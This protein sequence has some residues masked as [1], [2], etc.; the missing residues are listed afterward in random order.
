VTDWTQYHPTQTLTTPDGRQADI[1]M[2]MV[3]LVAELWQLGF[4]TKV[5][6]QDAGEA[7]REGGTRAT[8]ED[9]PAA[10]ASNMARAWLVV[11][12]EDA[13][14]LLEIWSPAGK[15][16]DWMMQPVKKDT[17]PDRWVSITF[18]RDLIEAA[19]RALRP[20]TPSKQN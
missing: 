10:A 7:V 18:P 8:P 11:R 5:A 20:L 19:V 15:P 12:R 6:C 1:D 13:P 4:E 3:P 17:D 2:E 9:R 14:R 16:G